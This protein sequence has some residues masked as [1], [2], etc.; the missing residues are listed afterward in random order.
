MVAETLDQNEDIKEPPLTSMLFR[1]ALIVLA[2]LSIW[3]AAYS[4]F[5]FSDL[6]IAKVLMAADALIVGF[7][8]ASL[9]HEWGHYAGARGS[10]SNTTRFAGKALSIFRFNFDFEQNTK[11]QF[12]WMSY[13]GQIGHW[14]ILTVL[15]FSLPHNN[16]AEIVLLSSIFGFCVFALLVEYKIIWQVLRGMDPLESLKKLTSKKLRT[17]QMIG[18][19]AGI[20]S[21][22]LLS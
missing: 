2:A 14:G 18:G 13:G 15:F 19:T 10:G 4:W 5:Q 6:L 21:I 20:A 1:D 11:T 22:I 8:V 7:I 9:F 12:L 3:A 16:L 17:A